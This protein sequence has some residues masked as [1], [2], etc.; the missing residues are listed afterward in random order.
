[1]KLSTLL[2]AGCAALALNLPN[3]ADAASFTPI[4]TTV[5]ATGSLFFTDGYYFHITCDY[6]FNGI[7]LPGGVI[8][9]TS[10]TRTGGPGCGNAQTDLVATFPWYITAQSSSQA[11][12]YVRFAANRPLLR[13]A[14]TFSGAWNNG[15]SQLTITNSQPSN[16]AGLSGTI[17]ISP[18]MIAQ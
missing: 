9:L 3:F 16:R 13:S 4:K 14:Q 2:Y 11:D 15:T 6:Q 18:T 5:V 12:I 7:N 1:M 10:G 8:E 17:T